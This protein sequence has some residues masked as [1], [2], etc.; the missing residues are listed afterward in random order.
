M[1]AFD[2]CIHLQLKPYRKAGGLNMPAPARRAPSK[3]TQWAAEFLGGAPL[4]R[5]SGSR[6]LEGE[7]AAYLA[8]SRQFTS[9]LRYWQVRGILLMPIIVCL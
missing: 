4:V 6:S 1:N 5:P 7:I 8:D 9:T 2:I 3:S